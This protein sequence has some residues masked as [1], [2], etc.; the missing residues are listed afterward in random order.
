M[1]LLGTSQL[2][3]PML[4]KHIPIASMLSVTP[5]EVNSTHMQE[6][7]M[8]PIIKFLKEGE[9]Q[10]DNDHIKRLEY[11]VFHYCLIKEMLYREISFFLILDVWRQNNLNFFDINTWTNG[12][13]YGNAIISPQ[14]FKARCYQSTMHKGA[15]EML[16]F[17]DKW[18]RF[19]K[20]L[21]MPPKKLTMNS[22]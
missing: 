15:K 4:T 17:C 8:Q 7:W 9:L 6:S 5:K 22:L 16:R 21:H 18:Q 11:K 3:D 14:G 20:V 10:E 2:L 12:N 19:F 1:S 13:H